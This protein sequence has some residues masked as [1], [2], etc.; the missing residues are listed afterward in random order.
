VIH[1]DSRIGVFTEIAPL[2][3][4]TGHVKIGDYSFIGA[5]ATVLPDLTVGSYVIVGAGAVVT[6]NIPDNTV[7][8]GIP[9]KTAKKQE[10]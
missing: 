10:P 2:A 1:H 4:I 6:R 5:N 7:V 3:V 8:T 9:A